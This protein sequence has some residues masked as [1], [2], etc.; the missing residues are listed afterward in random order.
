MSVDS[1][2]KEKT[3]GYVIAAIALGAAGNI[4]SL[5]TVA[6]DKEDLSFASDHNY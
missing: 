1:S 3:L 4:S 5:K 6:C 2:G